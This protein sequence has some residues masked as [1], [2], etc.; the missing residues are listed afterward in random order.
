MS[1]KILSK[2]IRQANKLLDEYNIP[3]FDIN[4]DEYSLRERI[5]E[6]ID[7]CQDCCIEVID[8]ALDGEYGYDSD[9][10]YIE[11]YKK[12]LRDKHQTNLDEFFS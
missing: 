2:Q 1:D 5:I 7:K 11:Y 4:G 9:K 6:L 3:S 8:S 12:L 10:K